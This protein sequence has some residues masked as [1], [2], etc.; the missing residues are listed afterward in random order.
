MTHLT[1][2]HFIEVFKNSIKITARTISVKTLLSER[3]LR[4]INYKPYYQRNY[5][6]DTIKQT[7]FI[8]SVILGTEIPPLIFFKSGTNIEVIDGR[9][10]YETLKRFLENDIVLTEKGLMSLPA[11]SKSTFN[12]LSEEI[13]TVFFNSNIRIYEFEVIV[14]VTPLIEDKIKKEI[15]R[16][17]NTGITPL[18]TVEIDSAKYDNDKLSSIFEKELIN[19]S[20]YRNDLRRCFFQNEVES[21]D[22]TEKMFDF[23]RRSFILSKFPISKYATGSQRNEIINILYETAANNIED[24]D[25]ENTKFK[26]QIKKVIEIQN[27]FIESGFAPKYKLLF[28]SILWAIRI[29]EEENVDFD[30]TK[31]FKMLLAHYKESIDLYSDENSFFYKTI[32]QRFSDTASLFERISGVNF[33]IYIRRN[34]FR[35]ELKALKQTDSDVDDVIKRLESLRINKPSPISKP[36]EEILSDVITSKYLIRPSYQRQEKISVIKA[37]SIIESILLGIYLPPIFIY[38][39]KS[40]EKEVV[41]GQQRLLS[42]IS[43]LGK[44]YRNEKDEL[45]YSLNNSYKLK[46]LKILT[47]LNGSNYSSL[48]DTDKDKILDFVIDE[49]IIEENLNEGFEPT[50]LF[51]RL[52]QKPYPINNNSFEMWNSTVDKEVIDK[53]KEITNKYISWFYSKESIDNSNRTDRMEN[54]ELVTILSY[55]VHHFNKDKTYDKVLGLFP[56]IDRITCRLKNKSAITDFLNKLEDSIT[57]KELF[58]TSINRTESLIIKLKELFNNAPT[59]DEINSFFNVK[60]SKT[61]RRSYQDFY[62]TWLILNS[63]KSEINSTTIPIIKN[64][65]R[66]MLVSLRNANNLE[67]NKIYFDEFIIKLNT[68]VLND[69]L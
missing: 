48:S 3:N 1:E 20:S 36:I 13:K 40:G 16:R 23:Q 14:G 66:E 68:K 55:I 12:K 56:R 8:E 53:I 21:P 69:Q 61:F 5:V 24:L 31:S 32:I 57:E 47:N 11:L 27:K 25:S 22:L 45:T 52:N 28:E 33:E 54:E 19:D 37:S 64:D 4:R 67:V 39:R 65:I 60:N 17:Y 10:R 44:Q 34:D 59:K 58:L 63:L 15:F 43:F 49:I 42:V 7:F 30:I 62:I 41:D 9:Q 6:W 50:D 35:N 38:K 18:T 51:I 2:Q 29:L 46:G 26:N